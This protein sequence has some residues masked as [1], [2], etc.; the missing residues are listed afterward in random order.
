VAPEL[1]DAITSMEIVADLWLL[2][3]APVT[4]KNLLG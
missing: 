2:Q 1:Q 3:P 4:S